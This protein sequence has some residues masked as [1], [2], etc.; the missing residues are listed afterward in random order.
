MGM[1]LPLKQVTQKTRTEINTPY[2]PA[3]QEQQNSAKSINLTRVE[4]GKNFCL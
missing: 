3:P 4:K 1:R 2:T